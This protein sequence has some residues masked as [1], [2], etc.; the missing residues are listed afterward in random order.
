MKNEKSPTRKEYE[1]AYGFIRSYGK[2]LE[3]DVSTFPGSHVEICALVSRD[4]HDSQFTGWISRLR[5]ARF[6][7]RRWQLP[8]SMEIPF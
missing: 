5:R 8:G 6:L 7:W 4:N 1:Y 3:K 2:Y